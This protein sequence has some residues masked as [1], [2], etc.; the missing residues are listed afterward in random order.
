MPLELIETKDGSHSLYNTDLDETYHSVHGAL[1]ESL[2]VFIKNGLQEV[3]KN[4]SEINILEVG[5]GTG[6]NTV[7]TIQ[8]ADKDHLSINYFTLEPSPLPS[9]VIEKLNYKILLNNKY[10]KLIHQY[11]WDKE[12]IIFPHFKFTKFNTTLQKVN[13]SLPIDLVYF[14]AF[15]PRVQPELWTIDIF[16]KLFE[17]MTSN[18]ILVTYCAKG[19]VKRSLKKAGFIVET[20]HGPP[21]KREMI[22]ARKN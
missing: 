6:L 1:N 2:H 7:L 17:M 12:N 16:E 11:E 20:L 22:R 10:F 8:E 13:L 4:S 9:D 18:A 19:E 21:G 5:F 14:D 3:A 15:A